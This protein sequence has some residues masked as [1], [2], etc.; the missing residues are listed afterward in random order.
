MSQLCFLL[1][2]DN[3]LT[4]WALGHSSGVVEEGEGRVWGRVAE[5]SEEVDGRP[6]DS[7][8]AS[9]RSNRGSRRCSCCS[10]LRPPSRSRAGPWEGHACLGVG[11]VG[12]RGGSVVAAGAD[13]RLRMSRLT[14]HAVGG[15]EEGK[16]VTRHPESGLGAIWG[17]APGKGPTLPTLTPPPT[18]ELAGRTG[19]SSSF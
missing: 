17:R 15:P 3:V 7:Q 9:Q 4:P 11:S 14:A 6:G 1:T 10:E 16:L 5:A 12:T 13:G 18:S 19:A 2:Q 8:P